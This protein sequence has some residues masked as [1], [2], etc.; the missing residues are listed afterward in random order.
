MDVDGMLQADPRDQRHA[1]YEVEQSLVGDGE[2]DECRRECEKD[3]HQS[4]QV[5]AVGVE[6][7]EERKKNGRNYAGMVSRCH[8][9]GTRSTYQERPSRQPDCPREDPV[10]PGER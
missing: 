1:E 4:V 5:V 10:S 6:S 8:P 2:D 9:G 7:V 3:D